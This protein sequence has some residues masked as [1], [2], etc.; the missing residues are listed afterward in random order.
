MFEA[1]LSPEDAIYVTDLSEEG[2]PGGWLLLSE[3]TEENLNDKLVELG[4][5]ID[6][7]IVVMDYDDYS[8]I[9]LAEHFGE[10]HPSTVVRFYEKLSN[11]DSEDLIK[12]YGIKNAVGE[13]VAFNA[14]E[15]GDFGTYGVYDEDTLNDMVIEDL[16]MSGFDPDSSLARY[17]DFESYQA[18]F[19]LDTNMVEF[20]CPAG[21]YYLEMR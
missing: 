3:L 2:W 19:I 4:L 15:D 5:D 13:D 7:E 21:T 9:D 6:D 8:E 17:F 14:V 18:D 20:V 10:A 11:L 12:F 1:Y 16:Q